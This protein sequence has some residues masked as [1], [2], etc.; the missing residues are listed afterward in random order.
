MGGKNK[1]T[2]GRCSMTSVVGATDVEDRDPFGDDAIEVP[3]SEMRAVALPQRVLGRA[4]R[5]LNE[6]ATRLTYGR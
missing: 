2:C 3:E 4:K 6:V 1:E 5:R